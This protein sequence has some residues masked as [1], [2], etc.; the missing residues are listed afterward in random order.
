MLWNISFH[1]PYTGSSLSGG[2]VQRVALALA[3]GIPGA[4]ILLLDGT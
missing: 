3:V 4:E 2:E 1:L